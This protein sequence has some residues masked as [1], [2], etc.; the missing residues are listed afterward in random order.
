MLPYTLTNI[1]SVTSLPNL[2]RD[3]LLPLTNIGSVTALPNQYRD[4][5]LPLTNTGSVTALPNQ[6]RESVFVGYSWGGDY[7]GVIVYNCRVSTCES[8]H[9]EGLAWGYSV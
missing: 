3:L 8:A 1:W 7:P 9:G 5:L 4:L 6:Y 2:Y